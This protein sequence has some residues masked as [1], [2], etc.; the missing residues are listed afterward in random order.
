MAPG[1]LNLVASPFSLVLFPQHPCVPLWSSRLSGHLYQVI[2]Y[3]L[4]LTRSDLFIA[5][6]PAPAFHSAWPTVGVLEISVGWVNE[7]EL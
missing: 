6:S 5:L 4:Q 7:S 3:F 2:G 1:M